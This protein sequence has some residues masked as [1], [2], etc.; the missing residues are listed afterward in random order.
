MRNNIKLVVTSA[1]PRYTLEV[2]DSVEINS[3]GGIGV[4]EVLLSK[5]YIVVYDKKGGR[6]LGKFALSD[7]TKTSPAPKIF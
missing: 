7:L 3:T 4:V 5:D 6:K 1:E 2:G